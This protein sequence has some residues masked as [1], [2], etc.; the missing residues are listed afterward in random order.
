MSFGVEMGSRGV[1]KRNTQYYITWI[2]LSSSILAG[3]VHLTGPK[4]QK[5]AES[6]AKSNERGSIQSNT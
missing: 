1:Q 6:W 4:L 2:R 5:L 3:D